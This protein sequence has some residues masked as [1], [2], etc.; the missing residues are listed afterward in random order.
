MN[1]DLNSISLNNLT[2]KA[3]MKFVGQKQVEALCT[4]HKQES[5]ALFFGFKPRANGTGNAG[6]FSVAMTSLGWNTGSGRVKT[7]GDKSPHFSGYSHALS[8]G[9]RNAIQG[10]SRYQESLGHPIPAMSDDF[11]Q[12]S[13]SFK[14]WLDENKESALLNSFLFSSNCREPSNDFR[15][16]GIKTAAMVAAEKAEQAKTAE[17]FNSYIKELEASGN[18]VVLGAHIDAG[19]KCAALL[20]I[21]NSDLGKIADLETKVKNENKQLAKATKIGDTAI[22]ANINSEI[23]K[24]TAEIAA[25]GKGC[26]NK[27]GL[28]K[29]YHAKVE[30]RLEAL[31]LFYANDLAH[32]VQALD[33]TR[34]LSQQSHD[35]VLEISE[36]LQAEIPKAVNPKVVA[37]NEAQ[38]ALDKLAAENAAM[39][40]E[41]AE[42]RAMKAAQAT[43]P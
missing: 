33:M 28:I 18:F 35:A 42:L 36:R 10:L 8:V 43:N 20:D 14:T 26:V 17:K 16:L 41:L 39:L 37:A 31:E 6:A 40:A 13:Q 22:V 15:L 25:L 19:E 38:A 2:G 4:T 27:D 1:T 23:A 5:L 12:L 21:L 7:D 30:A 32:M 11:S 9:F 29:D 3:A 24:L 34:Q